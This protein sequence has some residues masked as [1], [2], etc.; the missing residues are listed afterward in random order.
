MLTD[1]RTDWR[2]DG[3]TENRTPISHPATS[4]C[5]KKHLICCYDRQNTYDKHSTL[6][7][8]LWITLLSRFKSSDFKAANKPGYF[9]NQEI[10]IF[11]SFFSIK[12]LVV[13]PIRSILLSTY[14]M[15]FHDV[16]TISFWPLL[17]GGSQ[18]FSLGT[19]NQYALDN[20]STY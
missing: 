15:H 3:R 5:D 4:R 7:K 13:A 20:S 17:S 10:R 11:F 16:R 19:N 14:N 9:F 18:A 2:T 6:T 1:G 8:V 12:T